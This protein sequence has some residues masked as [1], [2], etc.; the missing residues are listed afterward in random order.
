MY[1]YRFYVADG[2]LASYGPD[3]A[4]PLRRAAAYVDRIA[5][6]GDANFA[7]NHER[8]CTASGDEPQ[9]D[10]QPYQ[11]RGSVQLRRSGTNIALM[12]ISRFVLSMIPMT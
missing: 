6:W 5:R 10:F 12:G 2:G 8:N 1:P 11:S 3:P 9:T 7:D 4:D